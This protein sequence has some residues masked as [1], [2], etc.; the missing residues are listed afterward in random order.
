MSAQNVTISLFICSFDC[1]WKVIKKLLLYQK[2][3]C[4]VRHT[5]FFASLAL[6]VFY[7]SLLT[8]ANRAVYHA[9]PCLTSGSI[10]LKLGWL[11]FGQAAEFQ[12]Q[13]GTSAQGCIRKPGHSQTS[14]CDFFCWLCHFCFTSDKSEKNWYVSSC[15]EEKK[16]KK[17]SEGEEHRDDTGKGSKE[18]RAVTWQGRDSQGSGYGREELRRRHVQPSR[19]G[20]GQWWYRGAIGLRAGRS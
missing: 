9:S 4:A 11:C 3:A 10:S 16:R 5:T 15:W 6:E 8:S 20:Q 2:P 17:S 1:F 13:A 14:G 19:W 12:S 7:S 18:E